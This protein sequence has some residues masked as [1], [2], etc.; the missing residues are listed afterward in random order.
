ME[1]QIKRLLL[2]AL[3]C[4]AVASPVVALDQEGIEYERKNHIVY[5]LK[6]AP[7]KQCDL[8]L[9]RTSR[10]GR[11]A[12]ITFMVCQLPSGESIHIPIAPQSIKLR[13]DYSKEALF[14]VDQYMIFHGNYVD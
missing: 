13:T 4:L 1:T 6:T 5:D 3:I 2:I 7:M 14:E 8:L 10:Q 9:D 12:N 11:K